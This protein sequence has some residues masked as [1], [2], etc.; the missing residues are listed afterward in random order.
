MS[1]NTIDDR[2]IVSRE[3]W[4][5]ARQQLLAK[6]KR[7]THERDAIAAERR[8]L[9]WVKVEK[10]Y[11]FDG[12]NG[13]VTLADL[14]DGKSQL[15]IY[16]FMFG[17]DWQEGCPSCSF[18]MDH[19]D[20]ALLHL[21]QRDVSFAATSRAPYAKIAAFKKRMGWRFNWVSS[22]GSDFNRDHHVAFTKEEV[23]KGEV[24]YNFGKNRFPSEEA[25]GISVFYKDEKG[26]VFHTY[27][28]YARGTENVVNTYNY[29]D[30]VPKGRDEDGLYFPMAWVR[31]HD[32]YEDGRLA[33]ADKPYW[34]S[35]TTI[36]R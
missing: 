14:F 26:E 3:E 31:H 21:A 35:Q 34:P 6:E 12:P 4:L 7:L 18:N 23:A 30:F 5:A 36:A 24:D 19:T 8:R 20:G 11:D 28:A 22:H 17:P 10:S 32:R 25:P 1:T 13:K 27:S 9:P 2:K 33:D 16:H 29:L 15:I